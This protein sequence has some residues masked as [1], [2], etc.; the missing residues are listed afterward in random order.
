MWGTTVKKGKKSHKAHNTCEQCGKRRKIS[1][2]AALSGQRFCSHR[3]SI[4][5]QRININSGFFSAEYATRQRIWGEIVTEA[6]D[7]LAAEW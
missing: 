6:L 1:R 2:H 3:C 7:K 4:D 5:W